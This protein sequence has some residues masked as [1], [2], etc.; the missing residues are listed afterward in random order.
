MNSHQRRVVKRKIAKFL[1]VGQEV[2]VS[3]SYVLSHSNLNGHYSNENSQMCD[4]CCVR[5]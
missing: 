4:S 3:T 5:S 2:Q 1:K